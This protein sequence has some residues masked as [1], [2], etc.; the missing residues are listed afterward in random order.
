MR[1]SLDIRSEMGSLVARRLETPTL[2]MM[3]WFLVR[4]K[5]AVLFS[6]EACSSFFRLDSLNC[7]GQEHRWKYTA[8]IGLRI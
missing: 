1:F 2:E 7:F 6:F 3:M 8:L 5:L 4:I